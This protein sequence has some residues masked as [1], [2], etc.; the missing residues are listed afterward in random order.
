MVLGLAL[1]WLALCDELVAVLRG[2]E[3]A[4]QRAEDKKG[5]Q[6]GH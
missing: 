3:P 6:D 5:I 2:R 4:F 1:F